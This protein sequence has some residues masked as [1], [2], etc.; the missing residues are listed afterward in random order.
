MGNNSPIKLKILQ[1]ESH[2]SQLLGQKTEH[3]YLVRYKFYCK[4]N[5]K[6]LLQ[7]KKGLHTVKR[8]VKNIYTFL[9]ISQE[10]LVIF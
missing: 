8:T 6:K 9:Q 10:P 2:G 1:L 7:I 3:L 5:T 4:G